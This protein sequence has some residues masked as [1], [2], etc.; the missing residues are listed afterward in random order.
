M[1][2]DSLENLNQLKEPLPTYCHLE[3]GE[4]MNH[5]KEINMIVQ[6]RNSVSPG[7]LAGK[8]GSSVSKVI[9]SSTSSTFKSCRPPWWLKMSLT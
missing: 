7:F 5:L 4:P 9:G 2:S 3:T 8:Q 1:I 6:L